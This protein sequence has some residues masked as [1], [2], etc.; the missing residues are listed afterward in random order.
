MQ[1]AFGLSMTMHDVTGITQ[2]T[3]MRSQSVAVPATANEVRG[4]DD[5]IASP[6]ISSHVIVSAVNNIYEFIGRRVLVYM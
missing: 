3:Q 5:V 2:F 6:D 1:V 4:H